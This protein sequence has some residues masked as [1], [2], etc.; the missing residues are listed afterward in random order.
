VLHRQRAAGRAVLWNGG[1]SFGGVV[2][3]IFADLI[4][5]PILVIY[6]KYYGTKMMLFIL[7]SFYVTMVVAGYVVELVFGGLG[8]VP[9]TRHAHVTEMAIHWNYT[10]VLNIAALAGSPPD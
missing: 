2:S 8:L 3:F 6:R 1:I 7:G 9:T 10:T 5:L 4:I